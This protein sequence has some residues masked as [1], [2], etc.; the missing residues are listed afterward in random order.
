LRASGLET[1]RQNFNLLPD[2][3]KRNRRKQ[4]S[5]QLKKKHTQIIK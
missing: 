3:V 4:L 1:V 2:I 5:V